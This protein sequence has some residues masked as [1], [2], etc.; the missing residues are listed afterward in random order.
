MKIKIMVSEL[1]NFGYMRETAKW[2]SS[3]YISGLY[4]QKHP[5]QRLGWGDAHSQEKIHFFIRNEIGKPI[6]YSW[7]KYERFVEEV[8]H[9]CL[10]FRQETN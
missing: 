3:E 7:E 1:G 10:E 4:M 9:L 2:F 5:E 8:V 6:I